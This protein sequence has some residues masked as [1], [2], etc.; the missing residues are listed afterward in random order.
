MKS[1]ERGDARVVGQPIIMSGADSAIERPPP[2]IGQHTDEVLAQAG[3][4]EDEIAGFREAGI[5]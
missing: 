4:S 1:Q 2:T 3:Y 5:T